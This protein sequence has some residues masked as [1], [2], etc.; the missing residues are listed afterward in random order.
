[1]GIDPLH[2]KSVEFCREMKKLG[3]VLLTHT[4]QEEAV[5]SNKYQSLGNPL[6]LRRILDTGVT[7]IMAHCGST[8]KSAD[9][10]KTSKKYTSNFELFARMMDDPKYK[11][12]LFADVSAVT[13]FNRDQNDLKTL[14]N[15]SD[16]H[17]RLINGSDYPLPAINFLIRTGTLCRRGFITKEERGWLNEIYDCNPLIFDAVLKFTLRN[18]DT[19]AKFAHV[20]FQDPFNG[21][22]DAN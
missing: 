8:G 18:P 13:M 5:E 19:G 21:R 16:W 10:D 3:M 22:F 12:N 20:V 15:R 6:L 14:L 1:M 9:L 17:P 7:V 4:G 11:K 2:D